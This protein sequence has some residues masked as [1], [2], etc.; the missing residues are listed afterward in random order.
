MI[1]AFGTAYQFQWNDLGDIELG[2]PNLGQALPVAVYRLAQ[3]TMREVLAQRY[4]ES[5]ASEILRESG[6][7][8]GRELCINTLDVTQPF[9]AFLAELQAKLKELGIG[10]M[11]IEQA[12]LDDLS[13]M[14]TVS[15]DLD[16]SGLPVSGATICEY[17]EGFLA[18]IL[19]AYTGKSFAVKE[20]DC[21]ATGD[22]TCRFDI[23]PDTAA[24]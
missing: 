19:H 15:E 1:P 14:I 8:A 12:N 10:V 17:D 6:W 18:G 22:R 20:I 4:G 7:I 16:C 9:S 23:K 5:A 11:R 21:W 24:A 3:Y 13:F 2:R